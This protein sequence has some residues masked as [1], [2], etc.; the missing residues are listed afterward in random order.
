MSQATN[1]ILVGASG[2]IGTRIAAM[3]RDDARFRIAACVDLDRPHA[4]AAALEQKKPEI[5]VDFSNFAAIERSVELAQERR[6][7]MLAGTTGLQEAQRR[8]LDGLA[9]SVPVLVA[10]N[11]SVGCVVLIEMA[12]KIFCALG[13][14]F[15]PSIVEWHREGKVDAPSGTAHA[16]R[17]QLN[18]AFEG[19]SEPTPTQVV[20][21]RSGAIA[22]E[23]MVRFDGPEETLEIVHRA[24]SRDLFAHGALRAAEWLVRQQPGMYTMAD[25]L[26]ITP[27]TP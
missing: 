12:Q 10:P 18:R 19:P 4:A 2:R 17:I 15:S 25:V 21:V 1:I 8:A 24:H 20:S 9:S 16:I 6:I 22:G 5:L 3:A 23:H 11:T 26:G 7:P 13:K 27:G 14:N